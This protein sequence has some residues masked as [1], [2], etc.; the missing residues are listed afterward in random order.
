MITKCYKNSNSK[1]T[2]LIVAPVVIMSAIASI[3]FKSTKVVG[4]STI[5]ALID[6]R[7]LY[8]GGLINRMCFL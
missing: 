5:I 4:D 2:W 3:T 8:V 1:Y 7:E 6:T